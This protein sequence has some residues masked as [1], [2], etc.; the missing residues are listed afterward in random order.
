MVQSSIPSTEK[1]ERKKERKKENI[2]IKY[3]KP[4]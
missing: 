1:K 3:R 2:I 4:G